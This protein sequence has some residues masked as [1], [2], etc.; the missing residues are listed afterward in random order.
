M[1]LHMYASVFISFTIASRLINSET[2]I[3]IIVYVLK[4]VTEILK[5]DICVW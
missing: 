2:F 1:C 5:Y 4:I 3:T